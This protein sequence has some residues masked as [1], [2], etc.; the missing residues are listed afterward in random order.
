MKR[1]VPTPAAYSL[2][3]QGTVALAEVESQGVCVDKAYLESAIVASDQKIREHEQL[4]REDDAFKT[5]RRRFG[6]KTN[7]ASPDQLAAVVFGDMGYTA[8]TKTKSGKRDAADESAFTHVNEPIVKHYFA[9]AKL[10]KGRD[11]YLTGIRR[12]MV[13]H[14]DDRTWR[15]HPNYN[16]NTVA[17]FRS[18]CDSPNWTNQPARNP[19]MAETVRR[20]FIPRPGHQLGE[21]DYGQIEVRIPPAY[22]FDPNLIKYCTDPTTDMHRDAAMQLFF[23]TEKQGKQ[24]NIRH[25]AKNMF[26]FPTFYGSYYAQCAP[27]I[28]ESIQGFTLDGETWTRTVTDPATGDARQVTEPLPLVEHL[29]RHGIAELGDC[30]PDQEPRRGTFERHLK[31]IEDHFWGTRFA[32]YAQWKRDW[33]NA[34][35][36]DGGFM[37]LTGFAVTTP[38]DRKQVCNYPIQGAA[39]HCTLWSLIQ[40]VNRLRRYNMRSRVVGEIHDCINFDIHPPERDDVTDMVVGVM[41]DEIKRWAPWLNVPLVVEPEICPVDGPW[42]NKM[43]MAK[44]GDRWAPADL[45]KWEKKYGAWVA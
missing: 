6:D 10:R 21:Y 18:S 14:A 40:I 37:M 36:R 29:R 12:E 4:I 1:L 44:T 7:I 25:V 9:A 8:K 15:I 3:H 33:Y 42:L 11:T 19:E 16:L 17:T 41:T 24:K 38:L 28:W 31:G 20:C 27:N 5:W 30:D 22:N 2:L 32:V 13:Y 45:D 43:V 39:F 26:V 34:Y 35:L 23:L